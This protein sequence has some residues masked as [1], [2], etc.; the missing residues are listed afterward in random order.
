MH[1]GLQ[2]EQRNLFALPP[3]VE[4]SHQY[5]RLEGPDFPPWKKNKSGFLFANNI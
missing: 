5:L 1:L 4:E 3:G 2:Q